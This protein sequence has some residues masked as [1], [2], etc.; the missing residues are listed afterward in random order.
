M[1]LLAR[2]EGVYTDVDEPDLYLDE[3]VQISDDGVSR[4]ESGTGS[5]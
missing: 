2:H 3:M 5:K 1:P 4:A